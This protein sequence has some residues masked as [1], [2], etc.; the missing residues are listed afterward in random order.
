MIV[1]WTVYQIKQEQYRDLL[2]DAQQQRLI[3]QMQAD[4]RRSG[5]GRAIGGLAAVLAMRQPVKAGRPHNGQAC[6]AEKRA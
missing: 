2:R 3:N 6:L 5:L 1:N 4:R